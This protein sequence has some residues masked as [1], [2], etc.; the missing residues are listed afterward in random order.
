MFVSL[1][2]SG[3]VDWAQNDSSY[4][5]TIIL[6]ASKC[7]IR[8]LSQ[9]IHISFCTDF[10]C[11]VFYSKFF[12]LF[13]FSLFHFHRGPGSLYLHCM[14]INGIGIFHRVH[15]LSQTNKTS[16]ISIISLLFAESLSFALGVLWRLCCH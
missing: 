15:S 7:N 8:F 9:F 16:L 13:F 12:K 5:N 6:Y 2:L 3:D 11:S 1:L 4:D 10:V 14:E